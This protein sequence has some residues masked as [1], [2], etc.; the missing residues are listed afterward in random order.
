MVWLVVNY[1]FVILFHPLRI[2]LGLE[3]VFSIHAGAALNLEV[4]VKAVSR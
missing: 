4:N 1:L 2:P 3:D